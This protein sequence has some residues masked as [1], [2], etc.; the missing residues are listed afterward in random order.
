MMTDMVVRLAAFMR[1]RVPSFEDKMFTK[2]V[3]GIVALLRF[4]QKKK[5][6]VITL[7]DCVDYA[8]VR[9]MCTVVHECMLLVPFAGP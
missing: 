2:E 4:Q 3:S 5:G 8:I 9:I 7:S 1:S 6:T